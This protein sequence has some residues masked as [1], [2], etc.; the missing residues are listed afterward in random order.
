MLLDVFKSDAFG[1]TELVAAINK[2]PYTPTKLGNK[3]L[4]SEEGV[5]TLSVAIEMQNGVLTLVPTAP[6]GAP[7]VAKNLE[8][9][10]IRDFRT[11]HL[12]QRVA[13]MAD[14]VQGLRAF[15]KQTE[16]EVAMNYLRKKMAVARRDLDIT[17]EWQRMGALRGIVLDADASTVLYNFLTE[18]GVSAS[19]AN[20]ALSNSATKVL[21]S[22]IGFKRTIED[23]L[24]GVA[25]SGF[26]CLCSAEFFDALTGHAAVEETYKYQQSNVLRADRRDGFEI[27]G[28]WFEEYRGSVGGERYIGANKALLYPTGVP[29]LFKTVYSPANYMESVNTEGV[30]FYMKSKVMDFD[31]GVEWQVQ[32]NP[33]HINTRPD[34]VIELTAT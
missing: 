22:I 15:G 21:Q 19:T 4:F 23:K 11:V 13:V 2:I 30:P 20:F 27:G 26:E 31:V 12:P 14:E 34:A 10:T 29:E 1:F 6:R 33:L 7:G 9:R 3:K 32:S 5:S 17:H 25:N 18:F 24:G 8:R 16:E 28:V